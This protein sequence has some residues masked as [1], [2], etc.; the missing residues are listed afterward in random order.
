MKIDITSELTIRSIFMT[1]RY[2]AG[3]AEGDGG[4]GAEL[5]IIFSGLNF[6]YFHSLL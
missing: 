4:G 2:V 3:Q 1:H 6:K 5:I